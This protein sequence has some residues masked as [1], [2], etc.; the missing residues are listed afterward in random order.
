VIFK[1]NISAIQALKL[2]AKLIKKDVAA[3]YIACN[4]T[5]VPIGAKI[6][7]LLV[8]AYFLSPIDLIPDFIPVLGMLDDSEKT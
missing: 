7:S 3:L 5:D 8:V 2:K 6:V 1:K 4:R